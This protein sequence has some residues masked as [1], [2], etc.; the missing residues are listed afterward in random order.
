M[1][2]QHQTFINQVTRIIENNLDN[3]LFG[4]SELAASINLSRSQL[5]RKLKALTGQS[6]AAFIRSYR[7]QKARALLENTELPIGE[8][9][10][11]VGYKDFSHFSRSF[12]KE[13]GMR[14]S[15]IRSL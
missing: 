3:E 9:A 8:I 4:V 12:F 2:F 14:P 1:E 10:L 13:L 7:L 5:H 11:Q 6:T 15:E